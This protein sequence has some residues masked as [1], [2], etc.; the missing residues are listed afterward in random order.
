[1]LFKAL[2]FHH[3]PIYLKLLLNRGTSLRSCLLRIPEPLSSWSHKCPIA[4]F[5][6]EWNKLGN[7]HR[8]CADTSKFRKLTHTYLMQWMKWF[9]RVLCRRLWI[10]SL[11]AETCDSGVNN[12]NLSFF[13]MITLLGDKRDLF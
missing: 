12:F 2:R 8:Q 4:V 7:V 5:I 1:M 11:V 9:E 6:S 10:W 13:F 3:S